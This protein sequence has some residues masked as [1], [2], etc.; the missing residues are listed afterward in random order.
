M[1]YSELQGLAKELGLKAN[2]KADKLLKAIKERYQQERNE[3]EQINQEGE[4]GPQDTACEEKVSCA[5]AVFVSTRR[6]KG[7]QTKRKLSDTTVETVPTMPP[8]AEEAHPQVDESN[9][10]SDNSAKR[11]KVSSPK[12]TEPEPPK[13]SQTTAGEQQP[14]DDKDD[15]PLLNQTEK[16]PQVKNAGRIPRL[17][18][19]TKTL[20][21]ITPNF[22]KLHEAHFNKM[23]SLDSYVQRKTK[24]METYKT[25]GKDQ[26]KTN[27][28][29]ASLF[30]PVPDKKKT[31]EEQRRQALLSP[32]NPPPKKPALKEACSFRPSVLSTRRINV[33]FSEAMPANEQKKTLVK[34]PA[35]MSSCL[36]S[37]TPK[38]QID[39]GN[40][41][42][43]FSATKTQGPFIFTGNL[44]TSTPG[45]QKKQTFDLKE[46][47]SRPL[48]YMPHKGKL[49]PFGEVKENTASNNSQVS[50][51]RQENYKNHKIQSRGER[52]VEQVKGRKQ[53]KDG[54]LGARRGLVMM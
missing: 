17:Q 36:A 39:T 29:R 11:R 7:N 28:A 41:K 31:A 46:S 42:K 15:G 27:S 34:T 52:R 19:K 53:K 25:S 16:P 18:Q 33:R 54:L 49:K 30:S 48:G 35:R 4:N 43:T 37:S 44:N 51:P 1:K 20:K 9:V 45:T 22:K 21:A 40:L 13:E 26:K 50:N 32:K 12:D 47:L 2:V 8:N 14:A 3:E 24:Q 6:G 5:A 38:M 10:P 23:E